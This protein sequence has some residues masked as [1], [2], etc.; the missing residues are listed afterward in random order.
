MAKERLHDIDRAKGLA[1]I[2]VVFGHLIADEFPTGNDWYIHTNL[3]I[4]KFHMAFFMF[5]TG[6]VTFYTYPEMRTFKDYA[7][8]VKKKFIR[9][10]PAYFL[11]ALIIAA[12]KAIVGRYA[13]IE[14]PVSGVHDLI[15][16]FLHPADSYCSSVWYIYTIFIYFLIVPI[17]LKL[18]KQRLE[19][20]LVL[21]FVLYFLPR[22]PYFAEST[23]AQYMFV[24]LL[25][26]WAVQHYSAYL[27]II[28]RYCWVFFSVFATCIVLYF[29]TDIPKLLFGLCSIPALHSLVRLRV[30]ETDSLLRLCAQYAFP[31][32]LANTMVIGFLRV[33]VQKY[34]SWDGTNFLV[35]APSLFVIVLLAP[36]AI[37]RIF[38]RN[39]P[40]LKTIIQA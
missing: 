9:L 5:I 12:G 6:V 30:F 22:S 8:Y 38:I 27:H 11:I 40:V 20:L 29:M 26:G 3:I 31:I 34:W 37:H 21:A 23:V 28:D 1:I 14:N 13:Y 10:I 7:T 39:T 35:V 19:V 2:L 4:Y 17:M 33:L 25:G 24:F 18:V 32:Y 15:G 36:I 16:A